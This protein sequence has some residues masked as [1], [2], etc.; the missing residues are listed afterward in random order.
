MLWPTLGI[1]EVAMAARLVFY[2]WERWVIH[3]AD[4]QLSNQWQWREF[5]KKMLSTLCILCE[6][7]C[8]DDTSKHFRDFNQFHNICFKDAGF[9]KSNLYKFGGKGFLHQRDLRYCSSC[10]AS[11]SK[12]SWICIWSWS[13]MYHK[14][15]EQHKQNNEGNISLPVA[16]LEALAH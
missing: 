10:S 2:I 14:D 7:C 6:L 13:L 4:R 8:V 16:A 15:I 1:N 5:G 12:E 9:V 11:T 3:N